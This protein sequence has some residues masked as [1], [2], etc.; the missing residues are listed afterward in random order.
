M[1]GNRDEYIVRLTPQSIPE[2]GLGTMKCIFQG[3]TKQ[4]FEPNKGIYLV[5]RIYRVGS[6][7]WVD[8]SK[9]KRVCV[10]CAVCCVMCDV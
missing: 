6:L 10:L 3:L 1:H 8:A 7:I 5:C 2:S 9:R 4:D